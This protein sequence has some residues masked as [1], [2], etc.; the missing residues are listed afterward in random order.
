FAGLAQVLALNVA[1]I[2]VVVAKA[3]NMPPE[4]SEKFLHDTLGSFL[5]AAIVLVQIEAAAWQVWKANLQRR[6]DGIASRDLEPPERATRLPRF[7]HYFAKWSRVL[8]ACAILAVL[9]VLMVYK[10][11]PAHRE[12][13][14]RDVIEALMATDLEAAERGIDRALR[15]T[16]RAPDLLGKKAR[17]Q[18]MRRDFQG[19]LD[20]FN[21]IVGRLSPLES[22]LKSWSLMAV[23]RSAD[24]IA[25]IDNLSEAERTLP[26]V[27]MVR[28]EYAAIQGDPVLTSR[29]IVHAGTASVDA[30]R[31]RALFPFLARHEQWG[32]IAKADTDVPYQ[33]IG[34]ALIAS[35]ACLRVND[36]DGAARTMRQALRTW[37]KD[38]RLLRDLFVLASR[39]PGTEWEQR[40]AESFAAN[41]DALD[42][43]D[44][45]PYITYCFRLARPD[46]AWLAYLR[47]LT[48]DARHPDIFYSPAQFGNR[49]YTF[50]RHAIGVSGGDRDATI[51]LRPLAAHTRHIWPLN[52][53]WKHVPL[54]KE[55]A[56]QEEGTIRDRYLAWTLSELESREK[57]G[58]LSRRGE[59]IFPGVLAAENRFDEAHA[60][61]DVLRQKYPS[62]SFNAQVLL[63]HA[64][65]YDQQKRWEE[66]YEALRSYYTS[67]EESG[68]F[69]E[70]QADLMMVNALLN[71]NLAVQA[72]DVAERAAVTFPGVGYTALLR[73][74]IWD[75]FGFQDQALFVLASQE[76]DVYL[77]TAARLNAQTGRLAE[78][79][80][81]YGA[82]GMP[83]NTEGK[84]L[85]QPLLPPPAEL[86]VSRRWPSAPTAAERASERERVRARAARAKSVLVKQLETLTGDWYAQTNAPFTADLARWRA[87]GRDTWERVSV[88]HRLA[89]LHA[90][91]QQ[92]AEATAVARSALA[93]M[94]QAAVLHRVL[95]ALTEGDR[96]VV[97]AA[98]A[99]C[100]T[101][102]EIWLADLV[103]TFRT[104]GVGPWAQ[105]ACTAA[106]ASGK[107]SSDT[108]VRAGDFLLRQGLVDEAATLARHTIPQCKGL[109]SAYMLGLRCA[110]SQ[111]DADWA[112]VC[113]R[114]GI[115]HAQDPGLFYKAVVEIKTIQNTPDADLMTALEYLKTKFPKNPEW[116][117]Y[118]G[119]LYFQQGNSGR[120]LTVLEPLLAQE[121]AG[122]RV[123][124]ILLAAEAA[125]LSGKG[126]K[127]IG[128]LERALAAHPD[129]M[130]VLN[131][132]IYSLSQSRV[133]APRA[134]ELL[135]RLMA[136][137]SDSFAVLDTAAMVYLRSG[138]LAKAQSFME[139]A[140]AK[141][142]ENDYAALE[143]RLNSAEVLM[144]SGDFEAARV[145]IDNV[146]RD[147]RAN[148]LNFLDERARRLLDEIDRQTLRSGWEGD[149]N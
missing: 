149:W 14:R 29:Y 66:S 115:Q 21:G 8:A 124:S 59:L 75:I 7:W 102:P 141:L 96:A 76:E 99:A 98:R 101:D 117:Q 70:L 74:A 15:S 22:T 19:A 140:M 131:N 39:R 30:S 100:P 25:I 105:Q 60:R 125:R 107:F 37:D 97:A 23:G 94:P 116:G 121:M 11:R 46:L 5:L 126:D 34:H 137:S 33:E 52:R 144:A 114:L 50:R 42:G 81:M 128:I 31:V 127:S 58:T 62:P 65:F 104:N 67:I 129:Q 4:W 78:A 122:V 2:S 79:Q 45:V 85:L 109:V 147:P 43:E 54:A 69:V 133:T 71:M 139:Q 82:L 36:L 145:R 63:E 53:L 130:S 44:L 12:Q 83:F 24:A 13:M 108:L 10:S 55:F 119:H 84:N 87:A 103:A 95:I 93:E 57:S 89:V 146:R 41:V 1:R 110:L 20:T 56:Q 77:Y 88:L 135:P 113:A 32:A 64:G 123:R 26:G 148:N 9:F 28:A 91:S 16:P 92:Y 90:R 132:L 27:A 6:L 35:Y 68:D 120:A 112:L 18:V 17:V 47:L 80:R 40:F 73:A 134:R 3:P 106:M 143:T 51:D 118:L 72:F 111:R 38:R 49:W 86:T 136:Y 48:L 61:L 142:D 138:D